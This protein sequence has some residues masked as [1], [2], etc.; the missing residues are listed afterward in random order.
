MIRDIVGEWFVKKWI[1]ILVIFL[2]SVNLSI[3]FPVQSR[4]FTSTAYPEARA[5]HSMVYDP[6]HNEIIMFGGMRDNLNTPNSYLNDTWIFYCANNSWRQ[7]TPI[8]SPATRVTHDMIYDSANKKAVL[9]GGGNRDQLFNDTWIFDPE[10]RTWCELAPNNRP[11]PVN[12]PELYY[13]PL[14]QAVI[15][16]GGYLENGYSDETW[17]YSVS[18]NSWEQIFPS[19]SPSSRY[20]HRMIY[21]TMSQTGFLFGGHAN[22]IS[23][24]IEND[25]WLFNIADNSWTESTSGTLPSTRYWHDMVYNPVKNESIVFGGRS[26]AFNFN[27]RDDTWIFSHGTNTWEEITGEGPSERMTFS[28]VYNSNDAKVYLYGGNRD[29]NTEIYN[30]MWVFCTQTRSWSKP[31]VT[32]S[33]QSEDMSSSSTSSPSEDSTS[34]LYIT[35]LLMTLTLLGQKRR[36][37]K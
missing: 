35:S 26:S 1:K 3:I 17:K 22:G 18:N 12:D 34:S 11:Q 7:I 24:R 32:S 9:F 28:M 4:V 5:G 20:G 13:D 10:T 36:K 21:N 14:N 31:S 25:L 2:I 8:I 19:N 23:D 29:P 33:V 30:D 15:L 37:R 6:I 27:C 16:F